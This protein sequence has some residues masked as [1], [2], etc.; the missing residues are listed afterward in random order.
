[1][2]KKGLMV[3][4]VLI[5]AATAGISSAKDILITN[6]TGTQGKGHLLIEVNSELSLDKE[7]ADGVT[8]KETG[9]ELQSIV[10]YG[11]T[12]KIDVILTLPYAWNKVT[13]DGVTIQK[14]DG[15][16]DMALELK[17][18]FYEK[19]GLSLAVKPGISLPT[20]DDE[21]G[22]GAGRAAYGIFFITT[23]EIHPLL[24]HL[25]LAYT[26]NENKVDERKDI[27]YASL[28][29]ELPL[30]KKLRFIANTGIQTNT[31]RMSRS[32]P[33]FILGGFNYEVTDT[34]AVN[35]GIKGGLN[36]AET[37]YTMLAGI[38]WRF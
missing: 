33:A 7:T 38:A 11:V 17:W 3:F 10:S 6:D 32:S 35:L 9:T 4:V 31:G 19:D 22:L 29:G 37:D 2:L 8:T 1:M 15:I 36:N 16:A 18:R 12:E 23:K 20:G 34:F 25:N 26:R 24:F 27:W 21:K 13:E 30:T 5:V 14:E 28:S